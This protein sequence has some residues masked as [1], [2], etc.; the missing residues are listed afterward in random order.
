M[1]TQAIAPEGAAS[2]DGKA[3]H[4]AVLYSRCP[5]VPTVSSL[6]YRLGLADFRLEND[7]G[8]AVDR[9]LIGLDPQVSPPHAERYWLR[10]AGHVKAVWARALGADTQVVAFSWLEGSYPVLASGDS[11]IRSVADLAGK[12]LGLV[13]FT[14]AAFDLFRAQQL[15]TFED[16]LAVAGL[17]LSDIRLVDIEATKDGL[18]AEDPADASKNVFE[19]LAR[20]LVRALVHGKVDAV[21]ANVSPEVASFLGLHVLHDTKLNDSLSQRVNPSVLR[22][23]VVSGPLVRDH[24]PVV[25]KIVENLL[26]SADWARTNAAQAI[27]EL[28][29]DLGYPADFLTANFGDLVEGI[30]VS[31]TPE[32]VAALGAQKDFLLRHGFIDADFD[33]HAWVDSSLIE[34]ARAN[35]RAA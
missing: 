11:G 32:L 3:V 10:H 12:R 18:Y 27:E 15:K 13:R 14:D 35:I 9:K 23:L 2:Q 5:V 25:V 26:R 4:D 29:K 7:S 28:G 33:I 16:T 21:A 19:L 31:F 1:A 6:A 20:R 24:R 34:E 8:L 22:C 17:S 30:Q